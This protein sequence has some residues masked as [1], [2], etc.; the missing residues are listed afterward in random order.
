MD[1]ETAEIELVCVLYVYNVQKCV[2]HL[3]QLEQN[4]NKTRQI[5]QRMTCE[6]HPLSQLVV[7]PH[8]LQQ[9]F[10]ASTQDL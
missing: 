9:F 5:S 7:E 2:H 6:A 10:P 8:L 1:D 3:S 4:L